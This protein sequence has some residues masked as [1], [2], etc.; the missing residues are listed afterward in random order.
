MEFW[1]FLRNKY[2]KS[3]VKLIFM[4]YFYF[5]TIKYSK[6]I[7]KQNYQNTDIYLQCKSKNKCYNVSKNNLLIRFLARLNITSVL[8]LIFVFL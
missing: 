8:Y 3:L 5:Y 4:V 6:K 7:F 1:K 2:V